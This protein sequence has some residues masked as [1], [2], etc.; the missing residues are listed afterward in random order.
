MKEAIDALVVGAGN[1]GRHYTRILSRLHQNREKGLPFVKRLIIS[2]TCLESAE[3]KA[4][5]LNQED[6]PFGPEIIPVEIGTREQLLSTLN[7]H[8]P[9]FIAITARDRQFGDSIHE[10]YSLIC[11][12]Y[13]KVLCEKPYSETAGDGKSLEN[14][15]LLAEHPSVENFGL[16]LPMIPVRKTL[17]SDD[18]FREKMRFAKRIHFKWESENAGPNIIDNLALH[19]WSLFPD[20][21][22]ILSAE[23]DKVT[24]NKRIFLTVQ[25]EGK[26]KAIPATIELKEKGSL[27]QMTVDDWRFSFET[28]GGVVA[29]YRNR[30]KQVSGESLPARWKEEPFILVN[31]PLEQNII[32]SICKKPGA[33]WK[34]TWESQ[35]FLEMMKGYRLPVSHGNGIRK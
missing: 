11:L 17:L 12:D 8:K 3:K 22:R 26:E 14:F 25:K 32:D 29:V 19:P 2:T 30:M 35:V 4:W 16:E 24:E 21:W 10:T 1:F 18:F 34:K 7:R 9:D 6:L 28:R 5:Q 33:G 31:N 20:T 13:G 27:R 15:H 23:S